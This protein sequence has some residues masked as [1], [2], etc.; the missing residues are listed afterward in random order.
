MPTKV[1]QAW[2]NRAL[3]ES[4]VNNEANSR[5]QKPPKAF[6]K[7]SR[8]TEPN[9]YIQWI[10]QKSV[11]CDLVPF[12]PNPNLKADDNFSVSVERCSRDSAG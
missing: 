8:R 1:V 6:S 2:K 4:R 7:T 9:I 10:Q 5:K 11:L 12:H 3:K